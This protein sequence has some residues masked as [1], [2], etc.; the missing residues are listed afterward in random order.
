MN[1]QELREKIAKYVEQAKGYG[2]A[3]TTDDAV[4]AIFAAFENAGY[5]VISQERK[6][7]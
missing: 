5:R 1:E 6:D 2:Y 4:T 7:V 3:M